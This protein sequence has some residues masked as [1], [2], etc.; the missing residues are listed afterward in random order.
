MGFEV[1]LPV[2]VCVCVCVCA[3]YQAWIC[4]IAILMLVKANSLIYLKECAVLPK[5][6]LFFSE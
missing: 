3:F 5:P 2:C 4:I 6:V 1:H